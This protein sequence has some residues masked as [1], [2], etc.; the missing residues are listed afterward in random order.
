MNKRGIL[1]VLSGPSGCGKGTVLAEFF[2]SH[3]ETFYSIS[4]TT[5]SPRVGEQDGVH[6]Y[7]YTKDAFESLIEKGGMLE[8]AVY[9]DHNYGTPKAP[10]FAELEKGHDVIVEI[11]AQGA[12]QVKQ[13]VPEAVMVFIAP[14]SL[15][16][17]R[18]RLEGRQTDSQEVIEKRLAAAKKEIEWASKYE[19]LIINDQ[20]TL[21]KQRLETII[22]AEKL[23]V[24]QMKEEINEVLKNA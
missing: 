8:Y 14:P 21:A 20:V 11:E 5:R 17:L 22:S 18:L 4:A 10:V 16:E 1:I 12:F 9:C 24:S 7:F 15:Q 13:R 23:R 6:Y 2:K 3:P 19:Y